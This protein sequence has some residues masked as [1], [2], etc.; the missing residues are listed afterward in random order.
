MRAPTATRPGA[1]FTAVNTPQNASHRHRRR[2]SVAVGAESG[3]NPFAKLG[4]QIAK[5]G[6]QLTATLTGTAKVGGKRG[7]SS[8]TTVFIA[9]ATGRLGSR[10][11]KQALEAGYRVRAGC[12]SQEK[13]EELI[14]TLQDTDGLTSKEKN[15]L[16]IVEFDLFDKDTIEGAI[17]NAGA[18][19]W[20]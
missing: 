1:A 10:I 8:D 14:E 11:V 16:Q 9:G 18:D 6:S 12:R 20:L 5:V 19:C 17:G 7:G 4:T 15:R 3:S 2:S 13:G